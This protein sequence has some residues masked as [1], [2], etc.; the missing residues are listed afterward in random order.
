MSNGKTVVFANTP[1]YTSDL[2]LK[3]KYTLNILKTA[4]KVQFYSSVP[5]TYAG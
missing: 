4:K 1:K 3:I 5:S 2:I